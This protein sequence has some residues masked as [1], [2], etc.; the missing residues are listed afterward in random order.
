LKADFFVPCGGRPQSVN[1]DNVAHLFE[2][3][4]IT[5]RFKNIVEGANLFITD[6]ARNYLQDRGVPLFKDASTNKGGVTSSSLEVLAGLAMEDNQFQE[7]MCVRE[8][9]TVPEFYKEYVNEIINIVE[10]NARKEFEYIWQI[11]YA[12]SQNKNGDRMRSTDC[13]DRLSGAMN[14]LNDTVSASDLYDNVPLRKLV[15]SSHIPS[16]L[17]KEVGLDTIMERVPDNYLR[18]IFSMGIASKFI[19]QYG[20]VDSPYFF[21]KFMEEVQREANQHAGGVAQ[22]GYQDKVE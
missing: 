21:Y 19:Y 18:A 4:G 8:D 22:K 14:D 1:I 16:C 9:G 20:E 7:H 12:D 6:A 10:T 11:A 13:T 5:P 17:I 15:L 3:D 2:K